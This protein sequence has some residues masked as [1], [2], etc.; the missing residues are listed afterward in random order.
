VNWNV[1]MNREKNPEKKIVKE[2]NLQVGTIMWT[3]DYSKEFDPLET[4]K[5]KK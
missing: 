2:E 1:D 4:K 3:I 5:N